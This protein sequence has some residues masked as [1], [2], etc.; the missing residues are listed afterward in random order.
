[1]RS[2]SVRRSTCKAP[3]VFGADRVDLVSFGF[4]PEP[5]DP[6]NGGV[7]LEPLPTPKASSSLAA[8]PRPASLP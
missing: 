7:A 8:M 3:G 4:Q 6:E 1:M 5:P 2:V